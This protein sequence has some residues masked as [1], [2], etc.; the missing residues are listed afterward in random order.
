MEK[1]LVKLTDIRDKWVN[2]SPLECHFFDWCWLFSGLYGDC[3]QLWL[4][5]QTTIVSFSLQL[6][7][8]VIFSTRGTNVHNH[9]C[10]CQW[11]ELWTSD[12]FCKTTFHHIIKQ[13]IYIQTNKLYLISPGFIENKGSLLVAKQSTLCE[14]G[15]WGLM[16]MPLRLFGGTSGPWIKPN[17]EL[18][19]TST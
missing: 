4:G 19:I 12:D 10:L 9:H 3:Y 2:H 11:P 5:P 18:L 1:A 7:R 14:L 6:F 8:I 13:C 15:V 16:V 17:I